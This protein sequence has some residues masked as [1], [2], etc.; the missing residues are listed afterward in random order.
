MESRLLPEALDEIDRGVALAKKTNSG[1]SLI[2]LYGCRAQIHLLMEDRK[3]AAA[4][5]EK[6]DVIRCSQEIVP[7]MVSVFCRSRAAL[8]LNRLQAAITDGHGAE[9]PRL[10]RQ[11][12]KCCRALLRQTRKVAQHRTEALCMMGVY[13]WLIR[14]R[15][16]A[17]KWWQKSIRVGEHMGAR[18]ALSRTYAEVGLRLAAAESPQTL[19]GGIPSSA[20]LEKAGALFEEM[21][22]E[23]DLRRLQ[24]MSRPKGA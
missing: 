3:A 18:I 7:W 14:K 20:Y 13:C 21:N 22:L 24:R 5:L 23:W 1:L 8:A 4:D 19:L 6:A 2:H 15:R 11:A 9:V 12:H 16:P 10:R 17:L